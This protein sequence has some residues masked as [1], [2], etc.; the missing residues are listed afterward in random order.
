MST[1]IDLYNLVNR[2]V[3]T[4]SSSAG[5]VKL[6]GMSPA[7]IYIARRFLGDANIR[8]EL[9]GTVSLPALMCRLGRVG[10]DCDLLIARVSPRISSVLAMRD[11]VRVPE[12]VRLVVDLPISEEARRCIR[13][14]QADNL[15]KIR[16]YKLS[17]SISRSKRDFDFIWEKMIQPYA[18]ERFGDLVEGYSYEQALRIFNRGGLLRV[19]YDNRQ[20]AG[21]LFDVKGKRVHAVLLGVDGSHEEA[22]QVGAFAAVYHFLMEWADQRGFATLDLGTA[23]PCLS[24]GVFSTK[25]R[26]GG[27]CVTEGQYYDLVLHWRAKNSL[28]R[29]FFQNNPLV[30]REKEGY[31]ALGA[32]S[33]TAGKDPAKVKA[34]AERYMAPGLNRMIVLSDFEH[35]GMGAESS[36]SHSN[37]WMTQN[38]G[39][40]GCVSAARP[41]IV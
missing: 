16:K 6:I 18:K 33:P 3:A 24:D 7:A 38:F 2:P 37:C 21:S 15:R 20:I 14:R 4:M 30:I 11:V 8:P 32:A 17:Y 36:Q 23:R 40:R 31:A 27:R 34:V 13:H 41:L 22:R 10:K 25:R 5:R 1:I 35:R 39:P 29:R 28:V 12:R 26:W 9:E 19:N